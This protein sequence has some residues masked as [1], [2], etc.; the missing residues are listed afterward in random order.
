MNTNAW[1]ETLQQDYIE[2]EGTRLLAL[3]QEWRGRVPERM[4]RLAAATVSSARSRVNAGFPIFI[5][6][7][8][9]R[10]KEQGLLQAAKTTAI[11]LAA[12]TA[13]A[14]GTYTL[15][16]SAP[17]PVKTSVE[18]TQPDDRSGFVHSD[19]AEFRFI[20]PGDA[21]EI[22]EQMDGNR[23]RYVWFKSP[24]SEILVELLFYEPETASAA[25]PIRIGALEGVISEMDGALTLTLRDGKNFL[26]IKSARIEREDVLR[27]AD[28]L[29]EENY[30]R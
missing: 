19:T 10:R 27:Y 8:Y 3:E 4:D 9:Q 25:E 18:Q 26:V 17:E 16:R 11:V 2:Q 1:F 14:A 22:A 23:V 7:P 21:F 15:S 13:V 12:A 6:P 30:G 29:V 5:I 20:S 24:D 28:R